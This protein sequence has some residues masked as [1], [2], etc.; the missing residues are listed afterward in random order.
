M[1]I[2]S[3][4]CRSEKNEPLAR[5]H[6]KLLINSMSNHIMLEKIKFCAWTCGA[7]NFKTEQF[8]FVKHSSTQRTVIKHCNSWH[9]S[10][11]NDAKLLN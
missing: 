9:T 5:S 4:L 8:L 1:F 6:S 3:P 11:V 10:N 2:E 7:N